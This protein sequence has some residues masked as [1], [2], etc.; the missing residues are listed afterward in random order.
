MQWH[1]F[2][3]LKREIFNIEFSRESTNEIEHISTIRCG[4]SMV[5]TEVLLYLDSY[6]KFC[7]N[8]PTSMR[9]LHVHVPTY[10]DLKVSE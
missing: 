7:R 4:A 10:P 1:S 9:L 6:N 3:R 5:P 2:K 8:C